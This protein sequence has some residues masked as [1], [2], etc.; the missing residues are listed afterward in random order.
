MSKEIINIIQ[1]DSGGENPKS[2]I[3]E[4]KLWELQFLD[5]SAPRILGK[6]KMLEYLSKGTVP[7]KT[8]HEFKKWEIKTTL[9]HIIRTWVVV[10]DDKSH[11]QLTNKAFYSL[12][13][14]GHKNKDEEKHQHFRENLLEKHNTAPVNP[15]LFQTEKDVTLKKPQSIT[16]PEEKEQLDMFRQQVKENPFNENQG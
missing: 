11:M 10:Y 4:D 13:T 9:G 12:L 7:A 14:N 16:T 5:E 6:I 1:N 8:V 2:E 15:A 3:F